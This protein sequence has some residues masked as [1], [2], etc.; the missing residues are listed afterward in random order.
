[1]DAEPRLSL[2]PRAALPARPR[3]STTSSGNCDAPGATP[4]CTWKLLATTRRIVAKCLQTRVTAALHAADPACFAKCAQ[5][6]NASSACVVNCYMG[7]LLGPAGGERV[8]KDGEGLPSQRIVDAWN[9]AFDS[10]DPAHGGCPDA[11]PAP[12][13]RGNGGWW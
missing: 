3:Y 11:P 2:P 8:I 10:A 7:A 13:S 5:P 6:T 9:G 4:N 1:M 12:P